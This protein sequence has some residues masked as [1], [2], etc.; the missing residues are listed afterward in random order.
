MS[1]GVL[2]CFVI[3]NNN[4]V[5]YLVVVV[6]DECATDCF[7]VSRDELPGIIDK[8]WEDEKEVISVFRLYTNQLIY[9]SITRR[10]RYNPQREMALIVKHK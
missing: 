4:L 5:R 2:Q 7:F 10:K 3:K 6:N 9:N 1:S 8:N